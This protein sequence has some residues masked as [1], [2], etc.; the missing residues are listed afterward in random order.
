MR[1]PY[2]AKLW[3]ALLLSVS[4]G[5]MDA[6]TYLFRDKVFANAQTGN[7]LLLAVHLSEG[8]FAEALRYLFPVAAFGIGISLACLLEYI[9][10]R[11]GWHK[12]YVL[13]GEVALLAAAA[14]FPQSGNAVANALV[15]LAC[16]AQLQ[17]FRRVG[18]VPVA[19]TM[20]IGN[21]RSMLHGA[22][23]YALDRTDKQGLYEAGVYAALIGCFMLGAVVGAL[24]LRVVGTYAIFGSS[25]ALIAAAILRGRGMETE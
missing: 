17:T 11:K 12:G 24:A 14:F 9:E 6:Y 8:D 7:I 25:I 3:F 23:R 15:S 5:L 18:A 20:C 13:W 19:T 4:G 2:K 16:G 10:H 21:F 22:W 1:A